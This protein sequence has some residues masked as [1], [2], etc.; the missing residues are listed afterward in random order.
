MNEWNFQE[1]ALLLTKF[2]KICCVDLFKSRITGCQDML[3]VVHQLISMILYDPN[4]HKVI[5]HTQPTKILSQLIFHNTKKRK[6]I[7]ENSK[8][9]YHSCNC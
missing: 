3:P 2:A 4:I 9:F 5:S 6:T 8:K 1:K 7:P